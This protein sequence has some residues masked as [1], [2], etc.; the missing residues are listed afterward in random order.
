M[1]EADEPTGFERGIRGL[2][3]RV[4]KA[5]NRV[6]GRHGAVWSDRYHARLLRTPRE[7]R[8]AL[9]Y[10]LNDWR[11]HLAR[12]RGLDPRSSARWFD[13]WRTSVA[14]PVGSTP[15]AVARTWLARIGWRRHGL[16]DVDEAPRPRATLPGRRSP[17]T[18]RT[19]TRR[20]TSDG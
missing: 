3:V 16:I 13:G 5:V 19:S 9:I 6:I 17:A 15:V 4:A 12:A 14:S 1:V 7:V 20:T 2:A 10:V 11:E 8:N 18:G